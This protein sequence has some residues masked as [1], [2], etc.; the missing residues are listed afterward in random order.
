MSE[1]KQK[2]FATIEEAK[3]AQGNLQ[4]F[5]VDD[6]KVPGRTGFVVERSHPLARAAAALSWGVTCTVA[7]PADRKA[8]ASPFQRAMAALPKL[9]DEEL[10]KL[11]AAANAGGKV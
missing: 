11:V 3:A 2:V 8:A 5:K 1:S 7:E 10:R 4:V 9:G 6:T